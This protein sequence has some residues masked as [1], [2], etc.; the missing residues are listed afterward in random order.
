M[1]TPYENELAKIAKN[2]DE[3]LKSGFSC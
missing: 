1:K 2:T 3:L